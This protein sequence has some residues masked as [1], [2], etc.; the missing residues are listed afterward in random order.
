MLIVSLWVLEIV[1][2]PYSK[3]GIISGFIVL[4]LGMT[5][6]ATAARPFETLAATA[7]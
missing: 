6:F 2:R 5:S 4:F 1:H 7:G 3:L